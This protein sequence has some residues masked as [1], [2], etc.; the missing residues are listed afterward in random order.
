MNFTHES[1]YCCECM[2]FFYVVV[3]IIYFPKTK[4]N[5]K[6]YIL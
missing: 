4:C 1:H 5:L 3:P 2:A 6:E